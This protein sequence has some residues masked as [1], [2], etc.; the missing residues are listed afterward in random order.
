MSFLSSLLMRWTATANSEDAA[1][2]RDTDKRIIRAP[3]RLP[4]SVAHFTP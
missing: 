3:Y 4:Q 1:K 2:M